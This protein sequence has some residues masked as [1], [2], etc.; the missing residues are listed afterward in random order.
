MGNADIKAAKY[1]DKSGSI[2]FEQG[3]FGEWELVGEKADFLVTLNFTHGKP[4][5]HWEPIYKKILALNDIS[6]VVVDVFPDEVGQYSLDFT[7]ILPAEYSL[8]KRMG[9]YRG[10]KYIEI[11][12]KIKGM[13]V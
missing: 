4:E 11:Y 6:K 1:L 13:D 3:V 12:A 7:K 8:V 10:G 2:Q 9:L 5:A